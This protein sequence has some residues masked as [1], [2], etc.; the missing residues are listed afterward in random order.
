[1]RAI[2]VGTPTQVQSY[3]KQYTQFRGVDFSTD[4]TQ[5]DASRSPAAQNIISDMKGFPE[6]RLG[7]RY[8]H[9]LNDTIH[10]IFFVVFAGGTGHRFV[11]AG[12]S[13]YTWDETESD[14]VLAVSG[15]A[16]NDSVHFAHAG[17]LYILDGEKYRVIE[18][19]ENGFTMQNVEDADPYI[20]TVRMSIT[21]N[22]ITTVNEE[23]F[24]FIGGHTYE[25]FESPNYLTNHRKC[26]MIGDATS[27]EYHL[28]ESHIGEIIHVKVNDAAVADYELDAAKG[29]ITFDTAPA[30]SPD[31][32][33]LANIE[34]EYTCE[35]KEEKEQK[36]TS[37]NETREFT[38]PNDAVGVKSVTVAGAEVEYTYENQKVTLTVAPAADV[39]IKIVYLIID[40][41]KMLDRINKCTMVETFGYFND[42]RFFF[43]GEA[44]LK[45]QNVDYMSGN[46]DPTYFPYDGYV[47]VGADSSPIMGYLKQHDAL[48]II[49]SDNE[50]DAQIF[51]RTATYDNEDGTLF[52]VMQGIKG[53]GAVSKKAMGLLRDDPLFLAEEGVFSVVSGSVKEQRSLQDRSTFVNARLQKETGLKNAVAVSWSGYFIV[54]V[55]DHCY[56]A[57]ARQRTGM[58]STEQAGYEW[59]Y[60]TNIPAATFFVHDGD[61]FFG[62]KDN[63][64]CK[65]N[66]DILQMKKYSD[67]SYPLIKL[68]EM[69]AEQA[70]EYNSIADEERKKA[71]RESIEP[72]VAIEAIWA[73]KADSFD[74]ITN[75]KNILKKGCAIMIKPYTRSS[76]E[77]GYMTDREGRVAIKTELADIF[78]FN[79][80][81]F[82]R[83]T[84]N[85]FDVPTVI[86]VGKKIKKFNILQFFLVSRAINEGFGVYGIQLS[87]TVGGYVK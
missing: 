52:P 12:T 82:S 72:G 10:S 3:T 9:K 37:D 61:L 58:S 60:W 6:K 54:C 79:D 39:E 8:I 19:T 40:E 35:P 70:E 53:V 18:K 87:Y 45:Y 32:A 76:I 47:R 27:T 67:A 43:A 84:F 17:K 59:Y 23:T 2:N 24:E 83:I 20:P 71:Y 36:H 73:T 11:H 74:T 7:W 85:T 51:A 80:I 21:G 4:S 25:E 42:N 30:I 5:V 28:P 62:S 48:L 75:V 41:N 46:D 26:T 78:D 64:I 31:G 49:K 63:A 33:G 13:L 15:L 56:V 22:A 29:Y 1:M 50:Q 68:S 69:T 44:N 81:D 14:P 66:S 86:P 38:L 55:N 65:F 57:D 77:L 34:V 16:D